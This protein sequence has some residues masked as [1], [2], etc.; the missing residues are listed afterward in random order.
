M[1]IPTE[2]TFSITVALDADD[3]QASQDTDQGFGFEAPTVDQI[4]EAIR[5]YIDRSFG[6]A[7]IEVETDLLHQFMVDDVSSL[8]TPED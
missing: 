3:V 2:Y 6:G 5:D 8:Y 1:S 7:H 4:E